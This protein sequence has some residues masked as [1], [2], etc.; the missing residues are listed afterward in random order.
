MEISVSGHC[1]W[2]ERSELRWS[3][4]VRVAMAAFELGASA[5]PFPSMWSRDV[6]VAF[7][8]DEGGVLLATSV[9]RGCFVGA[10]KGQ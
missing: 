7:W 6:R 3:R 9:A 1:C 5:V 8:R 10:T 4:D 2:V